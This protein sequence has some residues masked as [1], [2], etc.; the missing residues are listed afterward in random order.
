MLL[1]AYDFLAPVRHPRVPAAGRRQ[2]PV[3]QHH[4]RHRAHPPLGGGR[5]L[6]ADVPPGH[7][8]RRVEVRQERGRQRLARP[9][10]DQPVRVLPVLAAGGR[11]RR[12][13]LP[14]PVHLARPRP[15]RGAGGGGGRPARA[16][17]GPA[18][19]G[20]RGHGH[21]PRP[22]G[23]GGGP[24]GRPRPSSA[25]SST[26]ST[27]APCSRSS[28]RR[29]PPTCPG[30]PGRRRPGA[31]RPAGR[32]GWCRRSR[33]PAR[34]RP[35]RRYVNNRRETDLD[36]RLGPSDLLVG[37]YLVLRRGKRS[38]HLSALSGCVADLDRRLGPPICW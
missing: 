13:P 25:A 2:R 9:G 22:G 23:G 31:G 15:D 29:R 20:P 28:P 8:G 7:P 3:G 10:P 26:A 17:G 35:G 38:Y 21:G 27:S 36:R 33:P 4:R 1:Q 12:R 14:A 37:S 19:A 24:G 34:R 18:G 32:P 5:G 6:R 11:R 30:R 16:A